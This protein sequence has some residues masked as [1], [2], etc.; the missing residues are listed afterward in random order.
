[1]QPG[2][3]RVPAATFCRP[4]SSNKQSG[5]TGGLTLDVG[6]A[7]F[8]RDAAAAGFAAD[9][10][11]GFAPAAGL[12]AGAFAGGC[13]AVGLAGAFAPVVEP[14]GI[15]SGCWQFGHLTVLPASSS[16]AANALPQ[17]HCTLIGINALGSG[18]EKKRVPTVHFAP[19]R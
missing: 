19:R 12:A 15:F 9:T 10:A 11:A 2:Q 7:G 3:G 14:P 5:S 4:T 8:E 6:A 13:A 1:M 17:A 18:R 16:L